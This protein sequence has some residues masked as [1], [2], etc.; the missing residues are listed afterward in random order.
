[1]GVV[2]E[3]SKWEPSPSHYIIIMLCCFVS[4]IV[5]PYAS[6]STTT[7]T[8]LF[9]HASSSS[10]RRFQTSFLFLYSLSSVMEGMWSVFG[11][12]ELAY[13]GISKDQMVLCLCVGYASALFVGSLIGP[14]SDLIGQKKVCLLFCILHLFVGVWK[15]IAAHPS[16]W[17][18]NI[19]L[20]LATSIFL[21]N[22]ETWAVIEHEKQGHR[23]EILND[24]FWLMTFFES[25][26]LIGSQVLVNWLV[27][28]DVEK[29]IVSPSIPAVFLAMIGIICVTRG[30]T[31][32]YQTAAI[33]DYRKSFVTYILG[34]KR[35]MLLAW[36]QACLQFSIAVFWILWAPTLVAD[37]REVQLG[38]IH[39]CFLGARML[40]STVFPWLISGR[41]SLRTE[42][43]LVY[44]FIILGL[45]LSIIA[46]D[47]QEIGV[48]VTLF[49]LF[50]VCVGM[51]LPSF[52]RLR[53]MYVP[54]ELR[55]G[56]IS[57]SQAPANAAILLILMQRGYYQNI[58][59]STLIAF[60]AL[61]IFT[62]ACC[63]HLLKRWGKQP[64]QN[65]HK[66]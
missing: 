65:W 4:I 60:T 11:E 64:Y 30:W 51:I 41:T 40:G 54:N 26:S 53:T 63:M 24:T 38:V 46:Y 37:G 61:G 35:I 22:F 1:M 44:A 13:Y 36:A 5:F 7:T 6:K 20:S 23:Q 17:V 14:L 57:L 34:D 32:T 10:Y 27:G 31:D 28:S 49:C 19:C 9:D 29:G 25:A 55:G 48:L 56:M 21:F 39:S 8:T 59:N 12:F 42:V 52:A 43:C 62:A 15:R 45:V 2:I 66:L 16:F 47:Y 58:E 3:S 50:H 33:K 18:A